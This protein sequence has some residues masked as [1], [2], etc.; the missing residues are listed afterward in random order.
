MAEATRQR[1]ALSATR[2][3]AAV[4]NEKARTFAQ[5]LN[6]QGAQL[7]SETLASGYEVKRRSVVTVGDGEG[8]FVRLNKSGKAVCRR[9]SQKAVV[10]HIT[11]V[12]RAL[13]KL[14]ADS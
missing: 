6:P 9:F 10:S 2:R 13:P 4:A 3:A 8:G 14:V 12:Q 1:M 7:A 11:A 5:A